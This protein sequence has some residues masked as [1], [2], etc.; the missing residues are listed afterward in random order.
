MGY[1]A[2][3]TTIYARAYLTSKGREYLFNRDNIRFN[4]LGQDLFRIQ[5]FT[6][7]DPDINYETTATLLEG[8][9]PDVS[10]KYDSCLKTALDYEQRNM[11]FYQNFDNVITEDIDYTTDANG[12][13][14]NVDINIGSNDILVGVDGNVPTSGNGPIEAPSMERTG[15]VVIGPNTGG[16]TGGNGIPEAPTNR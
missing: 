5:T 14:V 2:S 13:L 12:N 16:N 4:S 1:L 10:G 8:Y 11:L 6:L 15:G 3:A 9:V 7:G